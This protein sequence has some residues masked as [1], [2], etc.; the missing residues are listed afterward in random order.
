MENPDKAWSIQ[1]K[2]TA[3]YPWY[4]REESA[5]SGRLQRGDVSFDL[6]SIENL[7]GCNHPGQHCEQIFKYN[8]PK[9]N[10]LEDEHL[11]EILGLV[12]DC[13]G[14]CQ[15]VRSQ[16]QDLLVVEASMNLQAT[17]DNCGFDFSIDET[18]S[19]D[20]EMKSYLNDYTTE[21]VIY[22]EGDDYAGSAFFQN[23]S[24]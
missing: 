5:G 22:V 24:N 9:C 13:Y 23:C 21:N 8:I 3:R 1:I 11:Y 16:V 20:L 15:D 2:S 7:S 4:V 17:Q 10:A 14:D 6:V 12:Y 18:D 19:V